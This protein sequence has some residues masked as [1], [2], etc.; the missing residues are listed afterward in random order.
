VIDT[1]NAIF[2]Q[3]AKHPFFSMGIGYPRPVSYGGKE[4]E[5]VDGSRPLTLLTVAAENEE[6]LPMR[7][8]R[9]RL[10]QSI[11]IEIAGLLG[12]EVVRDAREIFVLTRTRRE[13]Q[14]VADA[15]ATWGIPA[16][17]A[18]QEGLY[19]TE[20][21]RQVRDLLR[22]IADPH[23]PAKRLRAWLTPFF[24][25]SLAELPAAAAG[26]D[27]PLIDR[28]LAWHATAESGDLGRLFARI[29]DDSGVARRELFAGEAMRRLTNCSSCSRSTPRGPPARSATWRAAW[30]G[31]SRSWWFPSPRRGTRCAPRATAP[32]S[33]S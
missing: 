22:A 4:S 30:P 29:L 23:D 32:R 7:V 20:E 18:V 14:T 28:L 33:R 21:A 19:E 25:L 15:L 17:L 10:A 12:D 6:Q 27:Q 11:A 9:A 2:D 31:W 26:G 24:A 16:V 3:Q 8:V 5:P 13:S 1:Y